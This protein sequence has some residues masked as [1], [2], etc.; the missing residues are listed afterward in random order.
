MGLFDKIFSSAGGGLITSLGEVADKFIT[1]DAE[2]EK[3]KLEI[4]RL[5]NEHLQKMEGEITE[6]MKSED[7]AIS[8]R[9]KADMASDSWLSKN[10]RP[11][12][13]LSLLGFLYI[14]ILS[15][16]TQYFKF[17]VK[18]SYIELLQTLLVTTVV[19]YFG[20]RSAEK[21]QAMRKK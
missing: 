17:D 18:D 20:G 6:R 14:V 2:R 1:T 13:M 3:A 11:M 9:W 21:W 8:E 7:S 19:A 12:V 15:D 10:T 5:A 16:S 4:Q